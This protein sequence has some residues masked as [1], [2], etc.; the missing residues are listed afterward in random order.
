ML[1]KAATDCQD[2]GLLQLPV[3]ASWGSLSSA[4]RTFRDSQ[5]KSSSPL[6]VFF[7]QFENV[8]RDEPLTR[9]FRDLALGARDLSGNLLI[10][11]A[12]KTDLV[13]WTKG[14]PYQLRDEIRG[15]AT[16][17][18]VGPMGAADVETILRRLER[19]LGE[20]LAVELRRRLREYSQGLPWL[21][22]K[23]AGHLIR[24]VKQGATQEQLVN[25]ALNVQNLFQADLAELGPAE[26]EAL[27]YVAR[28][29]PVAVGEVLD[30]VPAAI[31]QSLL[32]RRLLVQVG[33]RLDTYWDIFRD[34]LTTGRVPVE[35]SYIIRQTPTSVARLLRQLELHGGDVSVPEIADELSTS[36]NAIFNLSRELRLL[37]VTSYEPNRVRL[38]PEIWE[39]EDQER[40]LRLRVS[41]SLRR[42]RAFSTFSSL[43]ERSSSGVALG[44]FA[45]EL[46]NAFPAVAVSENTWQAYARA[47]LMWFEYAGLA[48]RH[49]QAWLLAGDAPNESQRL[50]GVRPHR[51][52]RGGFPHEPPG[53]SLRLVLQLA[54]SA[55]GTMDR[56]LTPQEVDAARPLQML[57]VVGETEGGRLRLIDGA[58]VEHGE[59]SPEA[60]RNAL[61][62]LS[63]NR[64]GLQYLEQDPAAPPSELGEV[65]RDAANADWGS[66]TAYAVGKHFRSWARAAGVNVQPVARVARSVARRDQQERLPCLT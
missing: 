53:P 13:G 24:E 18:T 37:G 35:D 41:A 2:S 39:S 17:L 15:N 55:D 36:E 1:R 14:Y 57:G 3:D 28:Y 40:A 65:L 4:L 7:D 23:L 46:P 61:L 48:I 29:A 51:R 5:W 34:Y 60:L 56:A 25:E 59:V 50:L 64:T 52:I 16:V 6:L 10:G 33:E 20:P 62:R 11:F 43:L 26:Q 49:G 22:K 47:F 31:V 42:H 12:W 66:S 44:A 27:R 9:E 63:S 32:D 19:D 45:R 30:R 8:F 21:L 38:A 54:A 58:L